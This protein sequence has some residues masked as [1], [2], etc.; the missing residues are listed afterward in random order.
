[1][2]CKHHTSN[3]QAAA[4]DLPAPQANLL[5][6]IFGDCLDGVRRDLR[7]QCRVPD[8]T[9][10]NRDAGAYERILAGLDRGTMQI[11]DEEARQAVEAIATSTDQVNDYTK[12]VAEHMALYELLV[13]LGCS[14]PS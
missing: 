11:P 8:P 6:R 1:M 5:R 7:D 3:S 13:R 9:A 4:L 10:A 2:S 14:E 12:V